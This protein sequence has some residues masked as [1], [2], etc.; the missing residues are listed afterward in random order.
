MQNRAA[1]RLAELTKPRNMS[2]AELGRQ[3]GVTAQA[4]NAWIRGG[5]VP[6]PDLMAKIEDLTGIPMRD[7][8]EPAGAEKEA[9]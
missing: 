8:T 5:S 3:L 2:Q 7:W 4:V 9:S 6:S 1:Q